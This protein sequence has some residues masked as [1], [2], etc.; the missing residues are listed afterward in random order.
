M[1]ARLLLLALATYAC[2]ALA[3]PSARPYRLGV[4]YNTWP[5]PDAHSTGDPFAKA[6]REGLREHGWVEGANI[7]VHWRSARGEFD[8]RPGL[9]AELVR[10]P[11]DI[12]LVAGTFATQEAMRLTQS[13]PIVMFTTYAP[14][15]NRLVASTARPGGNVTGISMDVGREMHGKRLALLKQIA[16]KV[17]RVA[18]LVPSYANPKTSLDFAPETAAAATALGMTMFHASFE[19]PEGIEVA[20]DGAVRNGANAIVAGE[21]A[22]YNLKEN[23]IA[24]HRAA[25]R[26]RIPVMHCLSG[27]A[28]NGGLIS[29]GAEQTGNYRRAGFY[30]DRILK[31]QKPGEIPIEQPTKIEL[32]INLKAAKAIG[33][34]IPASVLAQADRVIN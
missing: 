13:I 22:P 30:V 12:I 33:L 5:V 20:I 31:G 18:F 28:E 3:Q 25:E 29:Y 27:T 17:S 34:A 6:F 23:Q 8:R 9:I 16:P 10:M 4:V 14:V 11:V 15:D 26:H 21:W 24:I 32:T 7:E 1:F 19:K 2:L